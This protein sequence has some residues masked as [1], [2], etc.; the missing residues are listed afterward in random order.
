MDL[1]YLVLVI[2]LI[3]FITWAIVTYVPMEPWVKT[4]LKV[5]VVIVLALFLIRSL[6]VHL[7]NVL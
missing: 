7:P 4:I 5:V 6:G 2:A 3:G 1:I